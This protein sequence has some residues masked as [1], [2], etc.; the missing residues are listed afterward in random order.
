MKREALVFTCCSDVAGKV[1]G[2]AFP[3]LEIDKRMKLGVGWTPT[4][5]QIT[6]FDS[7]SESPYG[8]L[9]D[10]VLIPNPTT[11]VKFSSEEEGIP[12]EQ[13]F[14]GDISYTDGNPWE[15][16]TRSI[17]KSALE[18]LETLAGITL[19]SAFE[20]EFHFKND[21]CPVGSSF[22]SAGFR[23]KR[24]FAETVTAMMRE[25]GLKPDTFMKEHGVDQ[26]EATNG[27]ET[28]IT[29]ADHAVIFREIIHMASEKLGLQSSFTPLRDPEGVGNGVHTHISFRDKEGNPCTYDPDHQ[30]GLSKV[31][32]QFIA[33]VLK[34]LDRIVAL[35]SP[36]V[37]SYS[38][39]TPHRWSAAF[40]NLGYRD[41]EAAVR[42][43]PVSDM[44]DSSKAE[45]FN[46]EFRAGDAAAS[47]YLA[48]AAIVHA[49]AQGIEE[50]LECPS[51][52][53]EDLSLL[54]AE[55]LAEKG[56]TRLPQTLE[57]ALNKF[58]NDSTVTNWFPEGFS[59]VYCKHKQGEIAYLEG[60]NEL[61]ICAAYEEVY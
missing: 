56:Y 8:S 20:H 16:C 58:A 61:E 9:G 41:R 24:E 7:I 26:Y 1:R 32:G 18:R 5:V 21:S 17:L 34:Y 36:S 10:L 22:S 31:T 47:P 57:Q 51:A 11:Q 12:D 44:S 6:C 38:R 54:S 30:Y 48:L 23:A 42:I 39:L 55:A 59:D 46:F 2:K 29:S 60:K 52:T 40:N 15:C 33:G 49:G 28:G 50:N 45:Q 19:Y 13:F 53:Q 14:I 37:I 3:L 4:N 25:A 27:P 43:C 35:T